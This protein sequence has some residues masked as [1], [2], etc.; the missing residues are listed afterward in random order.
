LLSRSD[1]QRIVGATHPDEILLAIP[2]ATG[3]QVRKILNDLAACKIP[4]KTLP[5]LA[6]L[7]DSRVVVSQIQKLSIE[8][9]LD[10]PPIGLSLE[11]VRELVRGKRVLIT[12]AGGSIGSVGP[13]IANTG[14]VRD[15][16]G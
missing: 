6:K 8:D 4:I 12:G 5:P 9:L 16:P 15:P 10:R 3:A 11:P 2:S 1:I 14:G 7:D 13:E